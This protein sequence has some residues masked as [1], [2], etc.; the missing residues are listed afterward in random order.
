ML[1]LDMKKHLQ[2]QSSSSV[3]ELA[4]KFKLQPEIV[5]EMLSV[6]VRKGQVRICMKTPKCG[7]QCTQCST[8]TTE[9]YE[10]VK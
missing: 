3:L 5:K 6:L 2:D 7:T 4:L 8:L 10:W 1:L 9:I